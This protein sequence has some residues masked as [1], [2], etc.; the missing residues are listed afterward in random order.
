MWLKA[1]HTLDRIA[2]LGEKEDVTFVLEN[3]NVVVDHPGT[4]F[5]LRPRP[6]GGGWR[7]GPGV[8]VHLPRTR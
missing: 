6:D 5:G 2:D 3:L 4:P 7:P 1:R 8:E